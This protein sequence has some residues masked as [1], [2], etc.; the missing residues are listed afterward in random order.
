MLVYQLQYRRWRVDAES[1]WCA[2]NT[3]HFPPNQQR[4][5]LLSDFCHAYNS[6]WSASALLQELTEANCL[7]R[8]TWSKKLLRNFSSAEVDFVFLSDEKMFTVATPIN[9]HNDRIYAP[10]AVVQETWHQRQATASNVLNIRQVTGGFR[11]SVQTWP[12]SFDLRCAR[13]G[14]EQ[15]LLLRHASEEGNAV[16]NP[17]KRWRIVHLPAGQRSGAPCTL[18][19]VPACS[20]DAQ[21]HQSRTVALQQYST[22]LNP[23]DY[24]ILGLM[25]EHDVY[26]SRIY[27]VNELKQRLIETR[28]EMQQRVIDDA[29]DEWQKQ[30]CV[31]PVN[32]WIAM[33]TDFAQLYVFVIYF[34]LFGTRGV[35][36]PSYGIALPTYS[37][38]IEQVL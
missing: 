31:S 30:S 38:Y 24:K 11:R 22:D 8:L 32:L 14:D 37:I 6:R 4:G 20:R 23:V 9:L 2:A 35:C 16:C 25:Q 33:F 5:R 36:A 27:D 17:L 15:C 26:K 34:V 1:R 29:I 18:N 3:R 7:A 13:C 28:T 19:C 10:T 12:H 21:I